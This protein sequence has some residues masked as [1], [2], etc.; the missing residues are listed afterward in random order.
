MRLSQRVQPQ[1]VP[2]LL[3]LLAKG[4]PRDSLFVDGILLRPE[5][6]QP[7]WLYQR[8]M[9]PVPVEGAVAHGDAFTDG[10]LTGSFPRANRAGWA[11]VVDDGE[12]PHW[13][14]FG[15]CD[16]VYTSVLRSELGQLWRFS[17]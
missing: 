12:N 2:P 1:Q 11:F 8:T 6:P 15:V 10:A 17:V 4:R 5:C 16:E 3:M 14:Q 13:G 7:P 9:G